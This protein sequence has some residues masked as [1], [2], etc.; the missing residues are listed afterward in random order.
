MRK[1][2]GSIKSF[3][4]ILI[5]GFYYL[6]SILAKGFFFYPKQIFL[7]FKKIFKNSSRLDKII[8][9]YEKRQLQPEFCLLFILYFVAT[10]TLV[11]IL[12]VKPVDVV[13]NF[14]IAS[15]QGKSDSVPHSVK[16]E[17]VVNN[18]NNSAG[19][20]FVDNNPFRKF[21]KTTLDNVSI[22]SLKSQNSDVVAWL[23][24]DGTS[25]N[26]PVV[27]TDNNDYYLS[28]SFYKYKTYNGWVFMDYR[29]SYNFDDYNTIFYG[30]NLLNKTAFGSLANVFTKNWVNNSNKSIIVITEGKT[31]YFTVFSAYYTT[32]ETYY[33]QNTFYGEEDYQN[34]LNTISFRNI[35]EIDNSVSVKDKI[36]TLS[37]C[38]DG[39]SGRKVVHAKL[40]AVY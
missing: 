40:V 32:P 13:H 9:H 6:C 17:E 14:D 28:H 11:K 35:L 23:S 26:Y 34:F 5:K 20:V 7:F 37:T 12:Y 30:H 19:T 39:S 33:L 4:K 2:V 18:D 22:E 25:I 10:C 24:V 38:N 3:F 29:N 21:A 31:Y 8:K 16:K 1:I 36:I 27:Q 15:L